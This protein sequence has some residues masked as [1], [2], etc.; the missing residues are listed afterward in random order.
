MVLASLKRGAPKAPSWLGR[1][2]VRR[3]VCGR[4]TRTA[5]LA[6]RGGTNL[7]PEGWLR[8]I[9]AYYEDCEVCG[10]VTA[11]DGMAKRSQPG[12]TSPKAA[13]GSPHPA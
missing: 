5:S 4:A 2:A 11:L 6:S 9:G 8:T 7:P 3:F 10:D 13:E 1:W 12:V